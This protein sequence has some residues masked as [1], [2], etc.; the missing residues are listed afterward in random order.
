MGMPKV[1]GEGRCAVMGCAQQNVTAQD[2]LCI[3]SLISAKDDHES[4]TATGPFGS[5]FAAVASQLEEILAKDSTNRALLFCQ[6]D[7]LREKLQASLKKAHIPFSTLDGT[8]QQMHDA[9]QRFRSAEGT[10]AR[11]LVLA[12]DERC[13]GA[14]LT[15]ANHVFFAHPL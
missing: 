10:D 12:L 15:A 5:K 2:L 13:A 9:M 4:I 3:S 6:L 11:V 8:P 1:N 7:P 14:N